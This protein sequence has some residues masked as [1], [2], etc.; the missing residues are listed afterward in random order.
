MNNNFFLNKNLCF[1]QKLYLKKNTNFFYSTKNLF[2]TEFFIRQFELN[3]GPQHPATHGVL[4]IT[5]SL[6]GEFINELR[7]HIG[8]L[9]RGTEKLLEDKTLMQGLPYFDRLDYV[10]AISYEHTFAATIELFNHIQVSPKIHLT[11]TIF[12]E[13]TRILN[14]LLAIT[15]HAIDLGAATPFL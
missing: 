10:S 13:L 15:T 2:H 14:H 12:L 11:R 6:K 5:L 9:H 3:F 4:R 8:F 7:C 1:C